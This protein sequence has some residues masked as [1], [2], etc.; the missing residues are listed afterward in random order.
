MWEIVGDRIFD[1]D[2]YLS[3]ALW[4]SYCY[5]RIQ[6]PEIKACDL[7]DDETRSACRVDLS[8]LTHTDLSVLQA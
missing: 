3:K 1:T 4:M 7:T 6:I 5:P 2:G 8:A